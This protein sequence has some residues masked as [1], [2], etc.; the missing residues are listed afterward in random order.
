MVNDLAGA[1]WGAVVAVDSAGAGV[2][3]G[4]QA[5]SIAR[6]TVRMN[7]VIAIFENFFISRSLFKRKIKP[8]LQHRE[9]I[10]ASVLPLI[11]GFAF[12]S[13]CLGHF[14]WLNNLL[15]TQPWLPGWA[16]F[17]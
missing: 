4:A 13:S 1:G 6:M 16:A 10:A 15:S 9:R 7:M 14:P 8:V 11:N 17:S 12:K 2:A 3:A 5:A